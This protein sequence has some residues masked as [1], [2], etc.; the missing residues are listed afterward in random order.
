MCVFA[1]GQ[2]LAKAKPRL[3]VMVRSGATHNW[4]QLASTLGAVFKPHLGVEFL[5]S[6]PSYQNTGQD[7]DDRSRADPAPDNNEDKELSGPKSSQI[8]RVKPYP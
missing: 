8:L 1:F 4:K 7:E 3:V 5:P 2:N 6:Y